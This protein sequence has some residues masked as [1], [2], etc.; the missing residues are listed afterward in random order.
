MHHKTF[1]RLC[2]RQY[3]M[4]QLTGGKMLEKFEQLGRLAWLIKSYTINKL[5]MPLK[6]GALMN[7]SYAGINNTWFR[8]CNTC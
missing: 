2:K 8:C 6:R 3:A 5:S 4:S 7:Y 1:L